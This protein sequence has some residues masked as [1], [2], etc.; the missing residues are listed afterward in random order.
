MSELD[1][2]VARFISDEDGNLKWDNINDVLIG[3]AIQENN[4]FR[5]S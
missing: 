5:N 1:K 3:Q 4:D 2:L